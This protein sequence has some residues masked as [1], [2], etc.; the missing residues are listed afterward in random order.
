MRIAYDHQIFTVQR[1]GG[2]SKYFVSLARA[3]AEEGH[4]PQILGGLHQNEYLAGQFTNP[5]LALKMPC[6]ANR[7][8]RLRNRLNSF[9]N[10]LLIRSRQPDIVHQ[11][12]QKSLSFKPDA[13]VVM[14][15]YDMICEIQPQFD[16]SSEA[17]S[18]EKRKAVDSVDHVICISENTKQDLIRLFATPTEKISVVHLAADI[19]AQNLIPYHNAGRPYVLVVGSR[20]GY[21][22]FPRLLEAL[23]MTGILKQA[24]LIAFGGGAFTAVESTMMN[25]LNIPDSAVKYLS[26]HD[27]F[28]N[29]V[30][31][32]ATMLIYPSLYEG[33][34]LPPLEAMAVGC[35]VASSN[36]SSMPEV[37]GHA[38]AYF[39]P[40]NPEDIAMVVKELFF[41]AEKRSYLS[42]AGRARAS[43]F[44][45][46]DTAVKTAEVYQKV[47]KSKRF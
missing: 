20:E 38:A 30:Y 21:K 37:L 2:I 40:E 35:P 10:R 31:S 13:P 36:T 19:P 17:C 26:G 39:A 4:M 25:S 1:Y 23:A 42:E 32:G 5:L 28:L 11:T 18:L 24:D 29:T 46:K 9:H 16:A 6:F 8:V 3:L 33:F 34:G 47:I 12:F 45:W 44:S 15:V 7:G 22:N 27:K 43:L 41:D 14:T